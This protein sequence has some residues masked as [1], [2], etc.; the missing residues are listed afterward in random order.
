LPHYGRQSYLV[1]DGAR[2]VER[3]VWPAP[4]LERPLTVS[5]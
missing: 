2:A 1:F 5:D 4:G 3:G